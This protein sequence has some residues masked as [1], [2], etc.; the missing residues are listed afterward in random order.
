VQR[1]GQ[2]DA[3]WTL[4]GIG[5]QGVEPET[6]RLGSSAVYFI[7]YPMTATT[8]YAVASRLI[9][10]RM[11]WDIPSY[12]FYYWRTQALSGT[13]R[14]CGPMLCR[15]RR[16]VGMMSA[17]APGLFRTITL[18]G[19]RPGYSIGFSILK[20]ISINSRVPWGGLRGDWSVRE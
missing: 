10:T 7:Q 8:A 14:W 15:S 20:E 11:I 16:A 17:L 13:R 9:S 4:D 12:N 1:Y 19:C 3:I 2:G 18:K 6:N 5:W